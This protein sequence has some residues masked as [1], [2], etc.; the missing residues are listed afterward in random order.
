MMARVK[1][2]KYYGADPNALARL[3]LLPG[4]DDGEQLFGTSEP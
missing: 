1:V 4:H 3:I 2:R